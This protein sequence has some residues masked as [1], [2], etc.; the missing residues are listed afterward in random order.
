MFFFFFFIFFFNY[1]LKLTV[2]ALGS[3]LYEQKILHHEDNI[4]FE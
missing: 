2:L 3:S 1:L 4:K